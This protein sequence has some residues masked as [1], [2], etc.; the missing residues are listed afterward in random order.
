MVCSFSVIRLTFLQSI[1]L[2]LNAFYFYSETSSGGKVAYAVLQMS[3]PASQQSQKR[4]D[5][6][7]CQWVQQ[8]IWRQSEQLGK[9]CQ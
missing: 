6:F 4:L 5:R 8:R 2:Y 9:C 7:D 1:A 3:C